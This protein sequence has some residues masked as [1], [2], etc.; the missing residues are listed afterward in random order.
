MKKLFI[1]QPHHLIDIITNSSSELFVLKGQTKEAIKEMIA[2]VYPEYLNEYADVKS[3]EELDID[4]LE[5][6]VRYAI[7]TWAWSEKSPSEYSLIKGY[8][9]E[10]MYEPRYKYDYVNRIDT[11]EINYYA[12]RESIFTEDNKKRLLD[13]L[14][15]NREMFFLFSHGDNS[16]GEMQERLET[17]GERYHLG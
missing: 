3:S 5:I 16:D 17:I 2:N 4:E 15:P 10:E 1:F 11:D 8:T 6:Y 13:A 14:D 12:L 9:F 7:S